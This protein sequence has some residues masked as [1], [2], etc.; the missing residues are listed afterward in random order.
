MST[1]NVEDVFNAL[2]DNVQR[3]VYNSD[4]PKVVASILVSLDSVGLL[5]AGDT[6]LYWL[7]KEGHYTILGKDD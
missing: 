1:I 2:M 5:V 4:L 6:I 3:H 7:Q